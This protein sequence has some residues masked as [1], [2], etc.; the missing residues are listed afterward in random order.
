MEEC[1]E[2]QNRNQ[3]FA[4]WFHMRVHWML[5]N[6]QRSLPNAT[7]PEIVAFY[8]FAAIKHQNLSI[9]HIQIATKSKQSDTNKNISV[10][11]FLEVYIYRKAL[12]VQIRSKYHIKV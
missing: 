10:S 8:P 4:C 7:K 11:V 5:K 1:P 9:V 12:T 6:N 3:A 2:F